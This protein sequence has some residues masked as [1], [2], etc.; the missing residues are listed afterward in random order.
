MLQGISG[1][2]WIKPWHRARNR[3][4]KAMVYN[5]LRNICQAILSGVFLWILLQEIKFRMERQLPYTLSY[6]TLDFWR[7]IEI[8]FLWSVFSISIVF[9]VLSL[10]CV[11]K[12]HSFDT[13]I[14]CLNVL[15]Y[16]SLIGYGILYIVVEIIMQPIAAGERRKGFIDN[17]LGTKLL[18]KSVTGYY[19]NDSIKDGA[20]KMMVNCYEN[21]YFTYNIV[22]HMLLRTICKNGVLFFVLLL[23]AYYGFKDNAIAIPILQ[24]FLSSL[25]FI[26]LVYHLVFYFKLKSLCEQFR[27]IFSDKQSQIKTTQYAIYMT[28]EYETALAY[29][30]SPNSNSVY[31][32]LNNKLTAE[33]EDIKVRYEIK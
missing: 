19:D 3:T 5:L 4:E 14:K 31:K 10:D 25:F 7:R 26:E 2:D 29:N 9:S 21:C 33:W 16:I 28:L 15:N 8:I 20:Y 24:I 6:K 22:K 32:K 23:F 17:S 13:L 12:L 1:T 27:N 30:K 11:S 18:E